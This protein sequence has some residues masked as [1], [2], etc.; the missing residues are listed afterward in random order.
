MILPADRWVALTRQTPR[1]RFLM[2]GSEK[3]LYGD[4]HRPAV[5]REFG[6][7][8]LSQDTLS[9]RLDCIGVAAI[10]VL[11]TPQRTAETPPGP[12]TDRFRLPTRRRRRRQQNAHPGE[13]HERTDILDAAH[14]G[15]RESL[16]ARTES[17]HRR[18]SLASKLPESPECRARRPNRP[19]SDRGGGETKKVHRHRRKP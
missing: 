16:T 2:V 9:K 14:G 1:T 15:H 12:A 7:P 4:T 5:T 17:Q 18:I 3:D 6:P 8:C 19:V 11:T 13:V 10:D